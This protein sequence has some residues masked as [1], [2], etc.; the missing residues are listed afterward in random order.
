M[1][2]L[3]Q[4]GCEDKGYV[5]IKAR[6]FVPVENYQ[7]MIETINDLYEDQ[8]YEGKDYLLGYEEYEDTI[9]LWGTTYVLSLHEDVEDTIRDFE[10]EEELKEWLK[11]E[12][13]PAF[14]WDEVLNMWGEDSGLVGNLIELLAK[15]NQEFQV[16]ITDT[17]Y[18]NDEF[19]IKT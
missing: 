4:N 18:W 14:L 8:H 13:V 11:N 2:K 9:I 3:F 7:A 17:N 16:Q 12:A 5:Q 10:E 1:K 6:S 15:P 19:T